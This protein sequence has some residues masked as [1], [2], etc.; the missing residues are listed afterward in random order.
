MG[1]IS[2]SASSHKQGPHPLMSYVKPWRRDFP[3]PPRIAERFRCDDRAAVGAKPVDVGQQPLMRGFVTCPSVRPGLS[4][5]ENG[6]RSCDRPH[7]MIENSPYHGLRSRRC[8]RLH[9]FTGPCPGA[10][11]LEKVANVP[12]ASSDVP[13]Y[14]PAA[15][16][17]VIARLI[18]Q[19]KPASSRATAV[20]ATVLSLPLR[21]NAR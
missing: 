1:A 10:G 5:S 6:H 2:P 16:A 3:A 15:P 14:W 20:T 8:T 7:R 13:P 17:G 18:A 4:R 11:S 19:M 12:L 21:I 9:S